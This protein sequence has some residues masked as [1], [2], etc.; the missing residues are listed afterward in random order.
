MKK[1]L[2]AFALAFVFALTP[3][4]G[5]AELQLGGVGMY[6]G[7]ITALGYQPL[8]VTWG[9]ESRLKLLTVFQIGLTGLYYAPPVVG[10]PSYILALADAG[11]SVDVFF[12][13]FGVGL[14]PDFLIPM[15]GPSVDATSNANLKLSGDITIGPV[16]VGAV[17]FYP[18]LSIWDLRNVS[19][20]KPWIGLTAMLRVF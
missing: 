3:A 18:V 7:D 14:G 8:N 2:V 9:M 16:S 4:L 17:M 13:R 5:R 1:A 12:L 20:V 15:S 6:N 10:G 11:L 19:G